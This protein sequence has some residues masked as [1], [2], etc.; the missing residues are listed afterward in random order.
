MSKILKLKGKFYQ[1]TGIYLANKEENEYIQS[2]EC[3]KSLMK[4]LS[5]KKNDMSPR[6][7][8]GL[9]IGMWQCKHG[10]HRPMS[11]LRYKKPGFLF[12]PLAWCV[13]FFTTAKWDLQACL[14]RKKSS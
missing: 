4:M 12:K 13:N 11:F 5:N 8:Q 1:Y 2:K 9:L 14:T 6:D 10:F 7:C 3:W